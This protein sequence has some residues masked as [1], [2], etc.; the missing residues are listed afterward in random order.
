[1]F[2][3]SSL[4]NLLCVHLLFIIQLLFYYACRLEIEVTYFR[5]E[6]SVLQLVEDFTVEAGDEPLQETIFRALPEVYIY[7]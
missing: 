2:I 7:R 6:G 3:S 5:R 4:Q 1:M